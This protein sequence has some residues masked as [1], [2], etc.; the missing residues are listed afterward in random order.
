M[1][2]NISFSLVNESKG[3]PKILQNESKYTLLYPCEYS[4]DCTP[5]KARL[6]A[7]SYFVELYGASGGSDHKTSSFRNADNSFIS[8]EIVD[9]YGGN[10]E[11]TS[12]NS[13]GG[14]GGYTSG[15]LIVPK[16]ADFY[17][18]IGGEGE[19]KI[20]ENPHGGYNGGGRGTS[21]SAFTFGGGGATDIRAEK[22]DL[23]HRVIVSG[24][25]GGSDNYYQYDKFGKTDDGSGGSG[26]KLIAQ[27]FFIDGELNSDYVATQFSG[28]SFGQGEAALNEASHHPLGSKLNLGYSDR[29][30][31]GGGWFGGFASQH[32]NGG[33]GGGSSFALTRNAKIPRGR[34]PVYDDLYNKIDENYYA[35]KNR[36]YLVTNAVFEAGIW[37]GNGKI[38]ITQISLANE[39]FIKQCTRICYKRHPHG[40]VSLFI[41]LIYY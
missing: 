11:P 36:K 6:K 2:K 31:A 7:G 4:Y 32:G 9:F 19:K 29:A 16:E 34:I 28:F 22:D 21:Y 24:A 15:I 30:G 12:H 3:S 23:F 20:G 26:G 14:S 33:A 37:Y 8:Q 5:Y 18:R 39:V 27:G 38:T 10:V 25:G 1:S 40:G 17:F 13:L 41:A 35:F